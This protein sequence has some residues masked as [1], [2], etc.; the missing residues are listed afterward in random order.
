MIDRDHRDK[1][2]VKMQSLNLNCS[3]Y[4][5]WKQEGRPSVVTMRNGK[6]VGKHLRVVFPAQR[7]DVTS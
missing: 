4:E 6:F 3:A 5:S 7:F 1:I 2:T